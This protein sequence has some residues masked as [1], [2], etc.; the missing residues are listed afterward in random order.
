MNYDFKV[1]CILVLFL[2]LFFELILTKQHV[3]MY[4][5]PEKGINSGDNGE[6]G[7]PVK[8]I[9]YGINMIYEKYDN[10][11]AIEVNFIL[12]YNYY[13][14]SSG[15]FALN[16]SIDFDIN[17]L[18]QKE[19]SFIYFDSLP[20][21]SEHVD[22]II[23][24]KSE[25]INFSGIT[26]Q[27][28][29]ED[30]S[31]IELE[32]SDTLV[33]SLT[34][35]QTDFYN[36]T[37][38]IQVKSFWNNIFVEQIRY[39]DCSDYFLQH[40]SWG[41]FNSTLNKVNI[42][43]SYFSNSLG[44][45][46]YYPESSRSIYSDLNVFNMTNSVF[47]NCTNGFIPHKS[48]ISLLTSTVLI[49][50]AD[51]YI[52]KCQFTGNYDQVNGFG[53]AIG[54]TNVESD[55]IKREVYITDS[56]FDN[57][58]ANLT[59]GAFH[60]ESM[61]YGNINNNVITN[62]RAYSSGGGAY[63][64][65][66]NKV[67]MT[68]NFFFNNTVIKEYSKKSTNYSP[69]GKGGAISC[70]RSNSLKLKNNRFSNNT[71]S[72]CFNLLVSNDKKSISISL[73]DNVFDYSDKTCEIYDDS[74]SISDKCSICLIGVG[75]SVSS[76]AIFLT[77]TAISFFV[78]LFIVFFAVAYLLQKKK[79]IFLTEESNEN[80]NDNEENLIHDIPLEDFNEADGNLIDDDDK[81]FQY[82]DD[83]ELLEN[84]I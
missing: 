62:N 35:Y 7:N 14:V 81:S 66:C 33:N 77:V 29:P 15:N 41:V 84:N 53:G 51:I 42:G 55:K 43:Q 52:N 60:I 16:R 73:D 36:C 58:Y 80:N 19:G 31:V 56:L 11:D 22:S 26:F 9:N 21:G 18:G 61:D 47:E 76:Q 45:D 78:F 24:F 8:N 71:A 20:E 3:E 13:Y 38:G 59:G 63:I 69:I 72:H 28:V 67:E 4:V 57:N 74:S 68:D 83:N 2:C 48:S 17:V 75:N 50:N 82:D 23:L 25:S 32:G 40:D 27:N 54:V 37:K 1:L 39:I 6:I 79:Y 30:L 10:L 34:I 65:D 64:L 12:N 46:I 44:I 5:D 70:Y 49:I